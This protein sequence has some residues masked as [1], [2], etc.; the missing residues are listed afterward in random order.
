MCI[1]APTA[2]PFTID[3]EAWSALTFLG[4]FKSSD[5]GAQKDIKARL[6]KARGAFIL[7]GNIWKSKE[8]RL[9]TKIRAYNS[10]AKSVLLYGSE[11]CLCKICNI[12]WP[13]KLSN[14]ELYMK[15]SSSNIPLRL[16][17]RLR[18]FGHVLRMPNER[19]RKIALRWTTT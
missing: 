10:N 5:N 13:N 15:T 3:G 17:H 14:M 8:Y 18:W 2:P 9:K 6:N 16:R 19:L 12:Y 7:L 4:I 1:N 11:C